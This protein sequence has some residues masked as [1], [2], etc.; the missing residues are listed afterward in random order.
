[1]SEPISTG[2]AAGLLTAAGLVQF[3]TGEAGI[4]WAAFAGATVF[5]MNAHDGSLASRLLRMAVSFVLGIVFADF[6][7]AL[8]SRLVPGAIT[9]PPSFG[10][11]IAAAGA[12]GVLRLTA[13]SAD[14]QGTVTFWGKKE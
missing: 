7:A 6:T 12:V 10:A 3:L 11:A 14:A 2:A 4:V 13:R 5:M 8:V 9:V 1:M